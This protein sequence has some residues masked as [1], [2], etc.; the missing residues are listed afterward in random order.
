[1]TSFGAM[2]PKVQQKPTQSQA[3]PSKA[4]HLLAKP[5]A[6]AKHLPAKAKAQAQKHTQTKAASKLLKI[7]SLLVNRGAKQ[8]RTAV[9]GFADRYLTTRTWHHFRSL[10][11]LSCFP[12]ASAKLVHFYDSSKFLTQFLSKIFTTQP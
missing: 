10:K 2:A 11:K 5:Q 8:I 12:I 7:N 4:K 9:D 1:M 6:K 3:P